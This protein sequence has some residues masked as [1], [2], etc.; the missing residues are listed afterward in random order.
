MIPG[1][2]AGQRAVEAPPASASYDDSVMAD[3]P[4]AYWK[5]D[6]TTGG[7]GATVS[8]ASGNANHVDAEFTSGSASIAD[9][10]VGPFA[11]LG[12][13]GRAFDMTRAL[14]GGGSIQLRDTTPDSTLRVSGSAITFEFWWIRGLDF[15]WILFHGLNNGASNNWFELRQDTNTTFG[16]KATGASVNFS[17]AHGIS[18]TTDW[19]LCHLILNAARNSVAYYRDGAFV[20]NTGISG[21]WTPTGSGSALCVGSRPDRGERTKLNNVAI[22]A[23]ALDASRIAERWARRDAA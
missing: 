22:Y 6:E 11:G 4:L 7:N 5:L 16:L 13:L 9:V 2:I 18:D 3:S 19:H 14:T 23:A 15:R 8:D 17:V 21:A 10:T 20:S 12:G 1:I